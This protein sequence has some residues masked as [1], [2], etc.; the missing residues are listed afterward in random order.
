MRTNSLL[1][2]KLYF[3]LLQSP[4]D[5]AS[6]TTV[7]AISKGYRQGE[8]AGAWGKTRAVSRA[9]TCPL[10]PELAG[11][12]LQLTYALSIYEAAAPFMELGFVLGILK[13]EMMTRYTFYLERVG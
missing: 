6:W 8:A 3:H 12:F 7:S 13:A 1:R 5:Q 9:Q 4:H 11:S 10:V 2:T